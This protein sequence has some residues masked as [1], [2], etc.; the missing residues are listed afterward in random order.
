MEIY[1]L[2]KALYHFFWIFLLGENFNSHILPN[3]PNKMMKLEPKFNRASN[4]CN[5]KKNKNIP[6]HTTKH[7]ILSH[8]NL[9]IQK[10]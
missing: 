8:K 1:L 5:S 4:S 2:P 9:Q 3:M 6:S 10:L 7:D